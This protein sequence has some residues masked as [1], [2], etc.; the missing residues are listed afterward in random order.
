MNDICPKWLIHSWLYLDRLYASS[1]GKSHPAAQSPVCLLL[2]ALTVLYS[3]VWLCFRAWVLLF[4]SK[5]IPHIPA[6]FEQLHVCILLSNWDSFTE[7][8]LPLPPQ[9]QGQCRIRNVSKTNEELWPPCAWI[10]AY[11]GRGGKEHCESGK[12][13]G[14]R[15][16]RGESWESRGNSVLLWCGNPLLRVWAWA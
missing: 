13:K 9:I 8:P 12:G 2:A 5:G 14:C 11:V 10:Q 15:L 6:G 1:N 7:P 16:V 3:M 4:G